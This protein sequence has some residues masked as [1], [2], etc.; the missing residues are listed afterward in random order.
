MNKPVFLLVAVFFAL[1]YACGAAE[2]NV[3]KM[4]IRLTGL[5]DTVTASKLHETFDAKSLALHIHEASLGILRLEDAAPAGASLADPAFRKQMQGVFD[6]DFGSRDQGEAASI[7]GNPAW[8]WT[9]ADHIGP[10]VQYAYVTYVIANEHL[11]RLRAHALGRDK[12]HEVDAR[13][14]D[15]IAIVNAIADIVFDPVTRPDSADT[16]ARPKIP[17]MIGNFIDL[18]PETAQ[19]RNERGV[20]DIEFN[21]DGNG[22]AVNVRQTYA[23]FPDLGNRIPTY[24]KRAVFK[25]PSN[26]EASGYATAVFNMEFQFGIA[27]SPLACGD[28]IPAR[29]PGADVVVVCTTGVRRTR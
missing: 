6:D 17:R 4:G 18:Y 21:V 13:P 24:L 12:P 11:Y 22:H 19:E 23:A 28:G 27:A 20:V 9:H 10:A 25:V 29:V 26:W 1:P 8:T 14:A 3:P 2:V 7:S 15:F 5:P 16:D